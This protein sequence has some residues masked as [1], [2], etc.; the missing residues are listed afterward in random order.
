[1]SSQVFMVC[2]G[3]FTPY[4]NNILCVSLLKHLSNTWEKIRIQWG[5][6]SITFRL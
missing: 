2:F 6:A 5:G 3:V 1:M 4:K